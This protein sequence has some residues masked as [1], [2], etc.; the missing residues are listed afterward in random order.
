MCRRI[1][2]IGA[3]LVV[4]AA[5]CGLG[6][7]QVAGEQGGDAP[8]GLHAQLT[9]VGQ[10]HGGFPAEYSG[11]NSLSPH[12]EIDTSI[13]ST[14]FFG[15]RL[16][17]GAELYIDPEVAGG[18]GLSGVVGVAGFPNGDIVRVTS[19]Q[20][21]LYLGRAFL[22]QT[23]GLGDQ[24]ERAEDD[25]LQLPGD[26]AVS[27]LVLTAGKLAATDIFDDNA[28]SHDTRTQFMNWSLMDGASWDYPADTRGYTW[29]VVLELNRP[30]WALRLGTFMV[31]LEAN[32]MALDH[33]VSRNHG[34]VAE[35]E[36]RQH[37]FGPTGKVKLLAYQNHARMGTY[38]LALAEAGPLP[39][40]ITTTRR[41]GT[42]KYGVGINVEQPLSDAVGAFARWGWNDGRTETWMFT[43]V[44]AT[45]SAGIQVAGRLWGRAD[46]TAGIAF[47]SNGLSPEHR[48]YLA[49]G[50][51]GFIIGDGALNYGRERILEAYYNFEIVKGIL[52]A[53]DFQHVTNPAYNRDRGPVSIWSLRLHWQ[54]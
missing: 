3:L 38:S 35:L 16:W 25:L 45:A 23:W 47:V 12:R 50:G 18:K 1:R 10:G 43:E 26:R 39:P 34:D 44:D 2:L 13:T 40:D 36:L 31:P 27:R 4:G 9:V 21:K 24:A 20:L 7:A 41:D 33:D 15:L 22:R 32:A 17:R 42:L 5:Q 49:A 37:L 29:G 46:D 53:P 19:P 28:Y 30:A 52:V 14:L 8:W 11:T 48:D 6:G 51:Y 54:M